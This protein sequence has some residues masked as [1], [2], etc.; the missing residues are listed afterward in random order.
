MA[1]RSS[2][3]ELAATPPSL[4]SVSLIHLTR[5]A[6]FLSAARGI[7][8]VAGAITLELCPTPEATRSATQVRI[9]FTASR[10]IGN[11]VARNLAKR[12]LRAA[13]R[14][15][16]PLCARPGHDYVLVAR[17][18]ILTRD[19]QALLGD[20]AAVMAAAHGRLDAQAG[21]AQQ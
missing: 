17:A 15:T 4:P 9:G 6:D 11:A 21:G 10:K 7:R 8:K 12:R 18:S 2:P 19:F 5:R 3:P 1:A 16:L 14:Q 13:A 20:L